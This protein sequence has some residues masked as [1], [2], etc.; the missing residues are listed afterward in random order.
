MD[1]TLCSTAVRLPLV[2]PPL[3]PSSSTWLISDEQ[4]ATAIVALLNDDRLSKGIEPLGFLNPFLYGDGTA[5]FND[6]IKG[7]NPGA[8]TEGFFARE[9]WDP[10][11][12]ARPSSF[13]FRLC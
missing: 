1:S 4:T 9:G 2:S 8:K 11:R 10:V 6:I 13:R 5:G 7:N 12:P 3:C